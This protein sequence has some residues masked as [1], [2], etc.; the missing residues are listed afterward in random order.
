MRVLPEVETRYALRMEL[1]SRSEVQLGVRHELGARFG[2]RA[3]GGVGADLNVGAG[4]V[5]GGKYWAAKLEDLCFDLASV[6]LEEHTLDKLPTI[7]L[8]LPRAALG[9]ASQA[10]C[11]AQVMACPFDPAAVG[12]GPL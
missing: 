11:S 12:P 9:C 7:Q 1:W 8:P 3:V 5:A 6:L 4:S 2:V 10:L